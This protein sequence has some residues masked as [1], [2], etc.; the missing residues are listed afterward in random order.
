MERHWTTDELTALVDRGADAG[1]VAAAIVLTLERSEAA[2][3]P[4]VGVLSTAALYQRSLH[5]AMRSHPW[6][7]AAFKGVHQVIDFPA[8][9]A[10]LAQQ[11]THAAAAGGGALLQAFYDVLTSLIGQAL[12]DSLLC[13]I[14]KESLSGSPARDTSS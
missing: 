6:L 12:T 11:S 4:V 13:A 9:S 7:G 14:W 8:L 1:Q 3:A 2:L 5:L 10:M